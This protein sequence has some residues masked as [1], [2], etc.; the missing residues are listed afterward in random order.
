MFR[1]IRRSVRSVAEPQLQQRRSESRALV[2]RIVRPFQ[3]FVGTEAAGGIVLL[4]GAALAL[5][6]A[7]W[8]GQTSYFHF[9]ERSVS[10]TVGT[11]E[12]TSSLR[13]AI[14]DGLMVVFF[15]L[16]GLEIKRE[17]L[18]GELSTAREAALPV[19]AALG[20]MIVPAAIYAAF[21]PVGVEARGW[22]IPMATD[23]AFALGVLVLLGNRIPAGLRVFLTA[24]AIVDDLGAVLVIAL[25]YTDGVSLAALGFAAIVLAALIACNRLGARH[26]AVYGALGLVLWLA[27][28]ESGV[29]P[30]VAGVLLAM[31][32]PSI[33]DHRRDATS[34]SQHVEEAAAAPLLRLEHRLNPIVAFAIM[35]L[36][37]FANAG[38]RLTPEVFGTLSWPIILGVVLGLCAGK[39]IGI[40]TASWA[41][42]RVGIATLPRQVTWGA[43]A[44][45]SCLGGI[46][47]T[48]SL[49]VATLAF[50]SGPLLNSAKVGIVGA[51]LIAGTVGACVLGFVRPIPR[52]E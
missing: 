29:H 51:S 49:F 43:M 46:G 16:V 31:T 9:W 38:V 14:N 44:G 11:L 10:V 5:I 3:Q 26:P 28:L 8:P 12:L 33:V 30:T 24:F 1:V 27:V 36:F 35:P 41:A 34:L 18:V 45:V 17:I 13:A 50:G 32:I 25:F 22:G 39:V 21:N 20:G 7:N 19:A 52:R 4:I 2:E 37:A 23:I 47:F 15:L 48:M 6:W 40:L 42:T